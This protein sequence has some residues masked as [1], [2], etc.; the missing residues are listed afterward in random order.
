METKEML[1]L[2]VQTLDS[3]QA[4]DIQ[5]IK[6]NDITTLADYFVI[7]GGTSSTQVKMLAEEVEERL[8]KEGIEPHHIEG[9]A[10]GWILL[11]YTT[12]IVHVLYGETRK[13]YNLEKLWADGEMLD[14]GE[15]LEGSTEA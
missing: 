15:F 2:M 5:V 7:A 13:F 1:K 11:D 10:T 4:K 12:I 9:R 14:V 3:K 8:S 6:V